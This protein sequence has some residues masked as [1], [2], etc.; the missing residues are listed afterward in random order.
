MS[1]NEVKVKR[2]PVTL[3]IKGTGSASSRTFAIG[4]EDHTLGNALR[5]VL[6]QNAKVGFSGYSVPH[7]SDPVV[8]IRVQANPPTTAIAA[9]REGC[10]TLSKQCDIVLEKLEEKLPYV[11]QDKI[12]IEEKIEQMNQEDDD[13][14]EMIDEDDAMEE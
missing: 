4:N 10:E 11:K 1:V 3:Q 12:E 5:H 14:D 6:I 9:L 2:S 8:Q 7:P 13:E